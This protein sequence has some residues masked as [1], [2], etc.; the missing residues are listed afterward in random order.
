MNSG[1]VKVKMFNKIF[2]NRYGEIRCGWAIVS[3]M[4]LMIVGLFVTQALVPNEE[5]SLWDQIMGTCV[6]GLLTIGGGLLLFKLFYNRG[7]KQMGIIKDKWFVEFAHG[8]LIGAVATGLLF[9]ILILAGE[10]KIISY[11]FSFIF[12]LTMVVEILS[13]AV[14]VFVE[15]LLTRGYFMT[16]LK[17]TRKKTIVF[18]ASAIFFALLHLANEGVTLISTFNTFLAGALFAYMFVKSGKLWMPIG[19]HFAWN[20]IQGTILG[21]T[22]SGTEQV[23]I[24]GTELGNNSLLS[25]GSYGVEGGLLVTGVLLICF[26]YVRFSV[27]STSENLWS[28]DSDLPLTKSRTLEKRTLYEKC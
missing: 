12:S 6:Y 5:Y 3:V 17:T 21:L 4:V 24:I 1:V 20:F 28:M 11:N 19:F 18:F 15:E 8:F 10:V 26:L 14:F 25:G 23:S 16:A 22:V 7:F 2:K 27:E 9:I 13:L